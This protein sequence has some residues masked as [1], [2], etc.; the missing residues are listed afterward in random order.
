VRIVVDDLRGAEIIALLQEHLAEMRSVSPPESASP[1]ALRFVRIPALRPVRR[2]CRR[3][4]Q[5]VHDKGAAVNLAH[6]PGA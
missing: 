1:R 4:E 5:R 6:A 3:P 2:L